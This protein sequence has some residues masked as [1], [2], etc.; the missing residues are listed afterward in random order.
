MVAH[1]PQQE[2]AQPTHVNATLATPEPTVKT[3]PSLQMLISNVSFD[4]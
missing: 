3:V 4:S 2:P 1:V